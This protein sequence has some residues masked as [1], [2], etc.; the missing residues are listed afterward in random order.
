MN[1]KVSILPLI[2][3]RVLFGLLCVYA[4]I[5]SFFK[6][7][8]HTRYLQP[9]FFF[10]YF[11]FEWLPFFGETLLYVCY[12]LWLLSAIG[13]LLGFLFRYAALVFFLVFTY[14]QLIDATNFINH[15]YAISL[16]SFLLIFIP[17]NRAISLDTKINN[18]LTL[19]FIPKAYLHILKF[20]I[21]VIYFFAGIAKINSDWLLLAQP[22]QIWLTP[23]SDIPFVGEILGNQGVQFVLSWMAMIF[24]LSIPFLLVY[25]KTRTFALIG[26]IVFHSCTGML[27]N[28]GLFPLLMISVVPIFLSSE[29]HQQL[30]GR[31]TKNK[32]PNNKEIK[33]SKIVR[34]LFTLYALVQLILPVRSFFLYSDSVLWTE[35]GYRFSWRVMLVEKEGYVNI[36]VTDSKDGRIFEVDQ[37]A[38]L[39]PFQIKR[40]SVRPDHLIQFAHYI[41]DQYSIKYDIENPVVNA[42]MYVSINGRPSALLI[43]KDV[44]L[45]KEKIE[46]S[47]KDFLKPYPY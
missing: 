3:F 9:Q 46:I 18:K 12:L 21:V 19:L 30:W 23:Y 22:L 40:M 33:L 8:I 37:N 35:E 28:I 29:F 42:Q 13:I 24:D 31:F 16:F 36:W 17:A 5:W 39:S 47:H 43:D 34:V 11:G 44:D 14:L 10:K 6:D 32:I 4:C 26:V 15:Y 20:Q 38:F 7:D 41:K 25:K 1:Q 27:L 45:S 2:T